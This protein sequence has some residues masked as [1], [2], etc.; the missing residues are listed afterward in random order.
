MTRDCKTHEDRW[1]AWHGADD[2]AAQAV[3][4]ITRKPDPVRSPQGEPMGRCRVSLP[5]AAS[6]EREAS[7]DLALGNVTGRAIVAIYMT[8]P[9]F[10]AAGFAGSDRTGNLHDGRWFTAVEPM[11]QVVRVTR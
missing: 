1:D 5:H 3:R 2:G 6:H 11:D 4:L 9:T 7:A 8:L 10:A